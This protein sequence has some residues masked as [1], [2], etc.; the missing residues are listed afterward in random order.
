MHKGNGAEI[1]LFILHGKER[2]QE[3]GKIVSLGL[4]LR[5]E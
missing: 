4:G 5:K 3:P 1:Y 2:N